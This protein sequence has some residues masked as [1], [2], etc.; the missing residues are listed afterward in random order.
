MQLKFSAIWDKQSKLTIPADG[1][2][3]SWIVKL[4]SPSFAGVP[5]NEYVM[6]ELA[7]KV[8]IDVPETALVPL[9]QIKGLPK[10]MKKIG[11]HAF[12]IKRFD[13][14]PQGQA[15]HTVLETV[16]N[17]AK[18]FESVESLNADEKV[19]EAIYRHLQTIPLW[20]YQ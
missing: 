6:M 17:F 9:D 12:V 14:G 19:L 7:K 2:G 1:I 8:G 11:S 5:Q 13:R 16:S 4:P 10:E 20:T 3:G 15:I 18:V